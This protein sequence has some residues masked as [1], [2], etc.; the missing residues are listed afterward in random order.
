MVPFA[1]STAAY[2][3]LGSSAR[4]SAMFSL[5]SPGSRTMVCVTKPRMGSTTRTAPSSHA[6]ATKR[7]S[8][9]F[10][11]FSPAAGAASSTS[12]VV[13]TPSGSSTACF[14]VPSCR[15]HTNKQGEPPAVTTYLES[16]EMAMDWHSVGPL[17]GE[18]APS[19]GASSFVSRFPVRAFHTHRD[20]S[21][22]A[23]TAFSPFA[24]ANRACTAPYAPPARFFLV[25]V[26][27]LRSQSNAQSLDVDN[28]K[29]LLGES[30]MCVT[31]LR[32]PLS[33]A[34]TGSPCL[35]TSN[36]LMTPVTNPA[37]TSFSLQHTAVPS[38]PSRDS[39]WYRFL[40]MWNA[41]TFPR[42]STEATESAERVHAALA[43]LVRFTPERTTEM[44]PSGWTSGRLDQI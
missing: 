32:W 25:Y 8:S 10:S 12:H 26:P 22:N 39:S 1:A 6:T 17:A 30:S 2:R 27:D 3:P 15:S 5:L 40:R 43:K 24:P 11:P 19:S 33:V 28:I 31:R 4:P 37:K 9:S 7:R 38:S 13:L 44:S 18:R 36:T 35:S 41:N 42:V 29:S 34:T 16:R 23:T 21:W 20:S 14:I